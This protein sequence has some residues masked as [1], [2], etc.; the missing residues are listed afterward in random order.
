MTSLQLAISSMGLAVLTLGV[1]GGVARRSLVTTRSL[2]CL[3][4]MVW[5]QSPAYS[6][7]QA[8]TATITAGQPTVDATDAMALLVNM[9]S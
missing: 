8:G 2:I 9:T 1:F 3:F 6:G 5:L 4:V 7:L